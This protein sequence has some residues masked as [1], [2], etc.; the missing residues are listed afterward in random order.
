MRIRPE[1]H[2]NGCRF[3]HGAAATALRRRAGRSGLCWERPSD[4]ERRRRAAGSRYP[5]V[6]RL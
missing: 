6:G 3:E 1:S 5:R 4:Q 2:V